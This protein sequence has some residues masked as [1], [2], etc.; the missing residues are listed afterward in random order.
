M[1]AAYTRLTVIPA[2]LDVPANVRDSLDEAL[3]AAESLDTGPATLLVELSRHAFNQSFV[4]VLSVTGV[5]LVVTAL[6][7]AL[8]GRSGRA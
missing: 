6:C 3:M 4:A 8:F 2:G 7:V 1:S 5:V